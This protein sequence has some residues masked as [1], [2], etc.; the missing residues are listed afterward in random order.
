VSGFGPPQGGGGGA[1]VTDGDKGDITVS[2]GG[3]VWEVDSTAVS[4]AKLAQMPAVT[5]KGNATGSAAVPNDL[6]ATQV[7][8]ILDVVTSS[9][10]GLAPASGGGTTNFLRAD[11]TWASPGGGGGAAGGDLTGTYPNP[12]IA[13]NVVSNAKLAQMP[14]TTI[15]GNST[16]ALANASDLT[17]TD[18]TALLDVFDSAT[19]GLTPSSGGGTTNFLRA[20]G[21]WA[22]PPGGGGGSVS[23][24][25]ATVTA[26][27]P[28]A[29]EHRI[30]VV[31]ALIS[32]T[33][34]LQ[35]SEGNLLD[36]DVN[37]SEMDPVFYRAIP[38][39]GSFTLVISSPSRIVGDFKI[40]YLVG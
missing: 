23:F 37:C 19:K 11:G 28:A 18:V 24:T 31:D 21:T 26:P 34:K 6:T 8:A 4:N 2:S 1:G 36:T 29:Q 27:A 7:T 5:L 35:I 30:T 40:N 33:S 16:G 39:T 22:A 15:K 38:G 20:D 3:T 14:A 13:N 17:G 9:A 25:S 32:G 12:T 10:Q